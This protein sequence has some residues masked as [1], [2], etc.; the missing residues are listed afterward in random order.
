MKLWHCVL[1]HKTLP[2]AWGGGGDRVA[3]VGAA[4]VREREKRFLRASDGRSGFITV[5]SASK[6]NPLPPLL[7]D[8][9]RW[10]HQRQWKKCFLVL[11]INLFGSGEETPHRRLKRGD[12]KDDD[13]TGSAVKIKRRHLS[14]FFSWDGKSDSSQSSLRDQSSSKKE[15]RK[16]LNIDE[17]H[18][19][20]REGRG[21]TQQ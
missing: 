11:P 12:R 4:A 2:T 16:D 18:L 6:Q 21:S 15:G 9:R 1:Q 7:K 10:F 5:M 3:A 8:V 17:D 13:D 14:F 20:G 19:G